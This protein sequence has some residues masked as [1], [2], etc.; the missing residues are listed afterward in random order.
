MY[1]FW[2][3]GLN[4]ES[5]FVLSLTKENLKDFPPIVDRDVSSMIVRRPTKPCSARCYDCFSENITVKHPDLFYPS[6]ERGPLV[7]RPR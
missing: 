5:L 4:V 1:V 2:R 7:V 6:E 3:E